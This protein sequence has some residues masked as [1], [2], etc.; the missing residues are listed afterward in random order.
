MSFSLIVYELFVQVLSVTTS[1]LLKHTSRLSGIPGAQLLF[2]GKELK[3]T[4]FCLFGFGVFN[5]LM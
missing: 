5:L 1:E 4:T 2:G 3:V